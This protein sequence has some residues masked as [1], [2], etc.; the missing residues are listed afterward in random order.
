MCVVEWMLSVRAKFFGH[1]I[2]TYTLNF[3]YSNKFWVV[4]R[5]QTAHVYVYSEL[6]AFLWRRRNEISSIFEWHHYIIYYHT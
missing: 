2:H 3:I 6:Q 4:P 1:Y 5:Q